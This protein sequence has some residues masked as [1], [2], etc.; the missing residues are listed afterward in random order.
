MDKLCFEFALL[1]ANNGKSN[2]PAGLHAEIIKT[3]TYNKV[4]H[5]LKK[6]CQVRKVWIEMTSNLRDAYIDECGNIQIDN[7]FLEEIDPNQHAETNHGNAVE[8]LL[9]KLMTNTQENRQP[10]WKQIADKFV[11]EKFTANTRTRTVV[12]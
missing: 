8:K 4:K 12:L 1:P 2:M 10:N 9:E 7:E 3:S 11:I 6:K 5:S